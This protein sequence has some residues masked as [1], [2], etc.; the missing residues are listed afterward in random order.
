L[1]LELRVAEQ[2]LQSVA[3]A[4]DHAKRTQ[5]YADRL[6]LHDTRGDLWVFRSVVFR[7]FPALGEGPVVFVNLQPE[8]FEWVAVRPTDLAA[9]QEMMRLLPTLKFMKEEFATNPT[10]DEIAKRAHLSPFHFHRRFTDL[11]GETPK[12]FLL[13]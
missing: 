4:V 5:V 10:L 2:V 12:R 9:D 7:D 8:G 3:T 1:G 11:M 13:S 6:M